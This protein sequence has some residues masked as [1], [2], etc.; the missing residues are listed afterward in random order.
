MRL[1]LVNY[2]SH[3]YTQLFSTNFRHLCHLLVLKNTWVNKLPNQNS[4][5]LIKQLPSSFILATWPSLIK[6]WF[7]QILYI[8]SIFHSHLPSLMIRSCEIKHATIYNFVSHFNQQFTWFFVRLL[9]LF[10]ILCFR[11]QENIQTLITK[12]LLARCREK[13]HKTYIMSSRLNSTSSLV[14]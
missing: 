8:D 9:L 10:P 14:L 1:C 3:M 13:G 11:E 2:I 5:L 4:N 7:M 6:Y 12:L